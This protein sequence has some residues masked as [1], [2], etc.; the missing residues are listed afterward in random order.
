MLAG[1]E[2]VW[3]QLLVGVLATVSVFVGAILG[4]VVLTLNPLLQPSRDAHDRP[5]ATDRRRAV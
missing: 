3:A 5:H 2:T 4:A 1:M